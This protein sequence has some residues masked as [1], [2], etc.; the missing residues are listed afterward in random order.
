MVGILSA[1]KHIL[2]ENQASVS[3][4]N[5]FAMLVLVCQVLYFSRMVV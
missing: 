2:L 4:S 3:Y 5:S 1:A